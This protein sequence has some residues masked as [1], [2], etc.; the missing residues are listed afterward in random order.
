MN[1]LTSMDIS[2]H[3]GT[4]KGSAWSDS[5]RKISRV[6][7]LAVKKLAYVLFDRKKMCYRL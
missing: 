6:L 3:L 7:F 2:V 5:E 4:F 1:E